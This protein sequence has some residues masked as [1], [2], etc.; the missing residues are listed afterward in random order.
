[1]YNNLYVGIDPSI[2]STGVC[3]LVYDL[4]G[5]LKED[6]FYIIKNGKLTKKEQ[7]A[8][9]DNIDKFSYVLL[10]RNTE[11]EDNHELELNKTLYFIDVVDSI[12]EI[13]GTTNYRHGRFCNIY[14]CI[15]GISYGSSQTKSVF[16]LAG[17]NFMIRSALIKHNIGITFEIIVG[18]PGELKKFSTGKGNSSKD[19][20]VNAFKAI[21]P[22]LNLPKVDDIADAYFMA[23]YMKK[24][25]ENDN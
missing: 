17:L 23:N 25:K 1:M 19:I 2:N 3:T 21:Y 12:K 16:D 15:E 5:N 18:T 4:D 8:E 11:A 24:I 7:K 10:E 13:I 20:I 9:L 6:R 22:N 14:V